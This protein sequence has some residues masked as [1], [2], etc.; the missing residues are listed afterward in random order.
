MKM[1]WLTTE[2]VE[3]HQAHNV[4]VIILMI[5]INNIDKGDK[6]KNNKSLSPQNRP[7]REAND[8]TLL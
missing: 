2:T 5:V 1:E 6:S 8:R 7:M 4:F 3:H